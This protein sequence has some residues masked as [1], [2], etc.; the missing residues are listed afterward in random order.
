[1]A[2]SDLPH[3]RSRATRARRNYVLTEVDETLCRGCYFETLS[4]SK[5]RKESLLIVFFNLLGLGF[6]ILALVIAF[7]MLSLFPELNGPPF[8]F[9]AFGLLALLDLAYRYLRLRPRL[10]QEGKGMK[11]DLGSHW[12]TSG[13]GGSLMFLPAWIFAFAAPVLAWGI[14]QL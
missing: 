11:T 6:L 2:N 10:Q 8:W 12:L 13:T 9:I 3:A 1:M 5:T 14:L 7:G 4:A